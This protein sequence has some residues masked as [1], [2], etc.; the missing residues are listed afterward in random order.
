MG[1][2]GLTGGCQRGAVRYS[3]AAI[4]TGASICH[5]RMCQKATGSPYGAYAPMASE[6]LEWTRGEPKAFR[7]SEIAE[8]GFCA[9]CGTPL[10]YRDVTSNRISVTIR[11]LDDPNAVAPAYQLDALNAVAW[12]GECLKTP[13][14]QIDDWLRTEKIA[15]VGS[16]QNPDHD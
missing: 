14:T 16:R 6:A 8:R 13:N 15:D 1:A 3:L 4:P 12:V 10:T 11:S 7:S 5:C 2:N 9:D